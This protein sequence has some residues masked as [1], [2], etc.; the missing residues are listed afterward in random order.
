MK[1]SIK[2]L[3]LFAVVSLAIASCKKNVSLPSS[4]KTSYVGT[5]GYSSSSG[6]PITNAVSGIATIS[7]SKG[8]YTVSFSNGVPALSGLR[9]EKKNGSYATV[10][11]NGSST[12]IVVDGDMFII[13]AYKDGESWS[14]TGTKQ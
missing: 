1:K 9:F 5:L 10:S 6:T 3:V 7:G 14:F 2:L 4:V 13:G 8:H 12:G 11:K